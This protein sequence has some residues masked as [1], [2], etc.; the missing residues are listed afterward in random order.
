M[1]N[2]ILYTPPTD[3]ENTSSTRT[4]AHREM[5]KFASIIFTGAALER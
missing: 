3:D 1:F 4:S 5:T 2:W